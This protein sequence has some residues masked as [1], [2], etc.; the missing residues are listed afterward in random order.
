MVHH[1]FKIQYHILQ[2]LDQ[3]AKNTNAAR[4]MYLH[5]FLLE[6]IVASI[7]TF[8]KTNILF[9]T[10]IQD[11]EDEIKIHSKHLKIYGIFFFPLNLR[12]ISK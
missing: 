5:H 10:A 11:F 1:F 7:K 2:Y 3:G 4:S 8:L 12:Y 9:I 6:N